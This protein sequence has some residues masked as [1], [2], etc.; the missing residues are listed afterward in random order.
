MKHVLNLIRFHFNTQTCVR[1]LR[2]FPGKAGRVMG[3][4]MPP[5]LI[6]GNDP[7]RENRPY[8][9]SYPTASSDHLW[10]IF[11]RCVRDPDSTGADTTAA[12]KRMK[13]ARTRAVKG[14]GVKEVKTYAALQRELQVGSFCVTHS[15]ALT[16]LMF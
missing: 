10:A 5:T 12:I 4:G 13:E 2:N 11:L 3:R 7:A 16:N 9:R 8:R 1:V 14:G 6:S 15:P